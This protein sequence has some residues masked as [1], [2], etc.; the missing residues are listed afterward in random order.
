MSTSIGLLS[1]P[2]DVLTIRDAIS[3][4]PFMFLDPGLGLLAHLPGAARPLHILYLQVRRFILEVHRREEHRLRRLAKAKCPHCRH[5]VDLRGLNHV[6]DGD[7]R[8]E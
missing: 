4:A 8:W 3:S 7:E 5:H 1:L 6:G 2:V